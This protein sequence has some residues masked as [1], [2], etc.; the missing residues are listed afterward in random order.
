MTGNKAKYSLF[1]VEFLFNIVPEVLANTVKIR[2]ERKRIQI[3]KEEIKL[4]LLMT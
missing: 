1:N 2:K 3:G 4:S